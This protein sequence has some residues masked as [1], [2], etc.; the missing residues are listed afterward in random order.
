M[1]STEQS[2]RAVMERCAILG[3]FSEEPDRLTRRVATPPMRQV[4]AVVAEWMAAAGM[5][6]RQDNIGNVIGRYEASVP[7]AKT[8]LLGSHVDTVRDAGRYDGPLGVLVALACVERLRARQ[9][10]LPFAIE[11]LAFADEEGLRFHTAYLGSKVV[12]GT[13]EPE[14]LQLSD[15]DGVTLAAAIRAYG[16]NPE[17]LAG[18]HWQGGDLLGYC[19]V[20]IEQG[21]VLEARG[22]PVG[23][24]SAIQ[25]Q[26]RIDVRWRGEAGH[27]GTVPIPLRRD[28][29]CAA[30]EFILAVEALAR[31]TPGLVATVG[32]VAI[33]PG[34]SNVI[35]GLARLSLDVRHP[36][37]DARAAAC[38]RLRE[39]A[40]EI[41]ASREVE[42]EWQPL[43]ENGAV[44]CSPHL[45]G[46]LQRAVAAAGYPVHTL[47]SGAGH[48]GVTMSQLTEIAM[49]FVR[50][51]GGISHNPAESV[52]S[53][54]VSVAI[55]VLERVLGL[56]AAVTGAHS[57]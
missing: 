38:Q 44:V 14:V 42:L 40:G 50:C 13:L 1:P 30:A 23:V 4:A 41:A 48:D 51:K 53:E 56:L 34:A 52:T 20:H 25:G 2:A 9:E 46:M 12:A 6:V 32:Q 47:P 57:S 36:D 54:D 15:E 8:L 29:L 27:A 16:G 28:A 43:Q 19:E 18:D 33:E 31:A 11:V 26:S 22:L 10:R 5:T 45:A 24:V 55:D 39:R 21:P 7:G 35:P 3:G 37:D 17:A 49:L